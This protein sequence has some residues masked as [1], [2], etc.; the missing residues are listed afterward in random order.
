MFTTQIREHVRER[1]LELAT[2]DPRVT[3]GAF[4][5]S[6]AFGNGDEWSDIDVAFGIAEGIPPEAVLEDWTQVLVPEWG[7]LHHWD[8]RYASSVYRVFLLPS[9]LEIDV[10]ATPAEDF[11]ARGPNFRALFGP[12]H[13]REV[14]PP[15]NASF[16]IGLCWHHVLHV[17]AYI[18]RHKPWQAEYWLCEMRHHILELACL[19][20]GENAVEGRGFDRLPSRVREPLA[21]AL[22][23]SLTEA[24]LRRALAVATRCLIAELEAW[25][26]PLSARLSPV[27]HEFGASQAS[28]H[29]SNPGELEQCRSGQNQQE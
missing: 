8:L 21:E 29:S 5:G 4:T 25:D 24:E 26:A 13:Q 3:A 12:S 15:S 27:L 16:L 1:V 10:A 28:E 22:V 19:R 7:V 11:G 9:G 2:A 23:R 20:L 18:E 17:R 6:M 14:R